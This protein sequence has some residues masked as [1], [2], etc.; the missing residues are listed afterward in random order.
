MLEMVGGKE[1]LMFASDYPHWDAEAP[2]HLPLPADWR[3]AVYYENA[4]AFYRRLPQ[5]AGVPVAVEA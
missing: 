3:P 4:Q 1:M 5:P 2:S